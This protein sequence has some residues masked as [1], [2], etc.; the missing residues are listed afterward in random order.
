MSTVIFLLFFDGF[1][2]QRS[3][4]PLM[5]GKP[6]KTSFSE[7]IFTVKDGKDLNSERE[8]LNPVSIRT[9]T[10]IVSFFADWR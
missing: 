9:A 4:D 5:P 7:K 10:F 1:Y 3:K 8:C 6:R 2:R